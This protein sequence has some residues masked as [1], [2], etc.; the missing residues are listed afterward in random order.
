M[1]R[2]NIYQTCAKVDDIPDNCFERLGGVF[3]AYLSCRSNDRSYE[4]DETTETWINK[5][6]ANLTL[7]RDM[8]KVRMA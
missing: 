6:C 5:A 2:Q 7:W 8:T 4:A 1:C 3:G